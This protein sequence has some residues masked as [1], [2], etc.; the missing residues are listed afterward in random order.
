VVDDLSP[1]GFEIQCSRDALTDR[2]R[3]ILKKYGEAFHQLTTGERSPSTDAQ[4]RFVEVARERRLPITEY[5]IVWRKYL[6]LVP[7]S[8]ERPSLKM[9]GS[10]YERKSRKWCDTTTWIYP[11]A[12]IAVRLDE[13]AKKHGMWPNCQ[14]WDKYDL[15]ESHRKYMV[16][17][18]KEYKG[19]TRGSKKRP[20]EPRCYQCHEEL[21]NAIDYECLN[22]EWV[23]CW[24]GACGCGYKAAWRS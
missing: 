5:E 2:E 7:P 10:T 14:A 3:A 12:T 1:E 15:V 21:D 9:S 13:K 16:S 17:K 22:C 4:T 19:V 24:C 18:G 11:A 23:L 20:R 8:L 6:Y